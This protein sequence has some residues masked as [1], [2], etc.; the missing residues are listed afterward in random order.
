MSRERIE[1]D[2]YIIYR[3]K[4]MNVLNMVS[5]KGNLLG[6]NSVHPKSLNTHAHVLAKEAFN[7]KLPVIGW[8]ILLPKSSVISIFE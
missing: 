8:K 1:G 2:E 7:F 3:E 6:Q 5:S 4:Y